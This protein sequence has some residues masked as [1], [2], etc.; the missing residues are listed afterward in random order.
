LDFEVIVLGLGAVGSAATYQLARRGIATLGI[1]QFAPPHAQGSTHGETRITRQA[2]GEGAEYTPLAQRSHVLWREIEQECGAELLTVTGGLFISSAARCA[3]V[4][5]AS[6]FANTLAAARRYGIR[7]EVLDAAQMR[8]RF[9][10]FNV[11]DTEQGY[12]E[13]EAGFLRPEAC[14]AA[15]LALAQRHGALLHTGERVLELREE[16]GRCW[17]V[18]ER[19]RYSAGRVILAVGPWLPQLVPGLERLFRVT[20][21]ITCW[22]EPRSSVE[23][24]LPDRF[25]VFI[26]E[27][28]RAREAIY[29]FPALHGRSGGV[30]IASAQYGEATAAGS[31]RR[32][33][34]PEECTALHESAVASC[35]P[36]LSDRCI[37]AESCLYTVTADSGFVIDRCPP[38]KHVTLASACS[39]HGFKHSAAL[40]EALAELASVGRSTLDLSPFRLSRLA[41]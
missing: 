21:Q 30:K 37:K 15:Q 2:I 17:V 22:F 5:V 34:G 24:F 20:R 40:G 9:P 8:H 1:D 19:A 31:V 12:F 23:P 35:F 41:A 29:G 38:F 13:Y 14:V 11:A 25:P 39:G 10:A 16:G 26:G 28:Q 6:F 7:H 4:H 36:L 32:H 27:P 33:I 3:D 18:S